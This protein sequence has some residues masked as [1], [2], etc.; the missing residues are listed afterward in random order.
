RY[1]VLVRDGVSGAALSGA[2]VE[3]TGEDTVARTLRTN[4]NGKVVFPSIES[5]VNQIIVSKDGYV[6]ADTVDV[7]TVV[8]ST[9]SVILR[10]MNLSLLPQGYDDSDT[11]RVYTYTVTVLNASTKA[12]VSGA[13]VSVT[14]GGSGFGPVKTDS[15]GRVSLD[16]LPSRQNLFSI[17]ASGYIS[18]DTLVV[19]DTTKSSGLVLQTLRV[20]L[21]P[22]ASE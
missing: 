15:N 11:D 1:T 22:S 6:P 17:D 16:S 7:V 20:L 14:S 21:S 18:L 19:A 2:D 9:A 12:A 4:D 13:S 10:T 3:L 8:D 5:Y